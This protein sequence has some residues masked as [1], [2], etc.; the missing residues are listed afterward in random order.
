MSSRGKISLPTRCS[1]CKY[2][3]V[4]NCFVWDTV[5]VC[6][7]YIISNYCHQKVK[8]S[9]KYLADCFLT[10][11]ANVCW[12]RNSKDF[13]F[14]LKLMIYIK[15]ISYLHGDIK[16]KSTISLFSVLHSFIPTEQQFKQHAWISSYVSFQNSKLRTG[17]P[18]YL[19][20]PNCQY[21]DA[22]ISRH[23]MSE[24]MGCMMYYKQFQ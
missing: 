20:S 19:Y 24:I 13:F 10:L 16:P 12:N 18:L 3:V 21:I 9:E 15:Y 2:N 4:E 22:C 7:F 14:T 23:Y 17:M 6:F 8:L 1:V 11:L 5:A